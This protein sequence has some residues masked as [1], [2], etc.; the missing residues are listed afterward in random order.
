MVIWLFIELFQAVFCF[1]HPQ[2]LDELFPAELVAAIFDHAFVQGN[3]LGNRDAGIMAEAIGHVF[4]LVDPGIYS[5]LRAMPWVRAVEFAVGGSFVFGHIHD[6]DNGNGI[7]VEEQI[8]IG[9][10]WRRITGLLLLLD[11]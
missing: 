1:G 9:I 7:Y 3:G 5:G 4:F 6:L 11:T 2:H 8:P 10:G